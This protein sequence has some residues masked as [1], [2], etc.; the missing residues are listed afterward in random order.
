MTTKTPREGSQGIGKT[1]KRPRAPV[2]RLE[3]SDEIFNA[4]K[5]ADSAHCMIAEAV[6][7]AYPEAGSI[8]VDLQTIRF[9]D[10][11]KR[12]R[13]I[14]LTPRLAQI[15]IVQFD[16]GYEIEPFS[17]RLAGGHVIS[18]FTRRRK[19]S[20]QMTPGL[21]KAQLTKQGLRQGYN[22]GVPERVGGKSPPTT[23]FSR[24]RAFGLRA[25]Q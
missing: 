12:L 8:S 13:Y 1:P 5:K 11:N 14:Y 23:P 10:P 25:L 7:T 21:A 22:K 4:A 24:R 20:G 6:R 19:T 16:Q 9:S 18:M 2:L 17:F 3:I 15:G